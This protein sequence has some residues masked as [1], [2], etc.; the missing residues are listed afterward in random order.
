MERSND[1]YGS[2]RMWFGLSVLVIILCAILFFVGRYGSLMYAA[3]HVPPA[4][5]STPPPTAQ[6]FFA[7]ATAFAA[8]LSTTTTQREL[9]AL[10]IA[11]VVPP[12]G[13]FIAADLTNMKLYLFQD[14]TTTAEFPILTKGKPGTPWETPSGVYTVLTKEVDHYNAVEQVHMPYSMEFYGNYFI[15][16]WPT[17]D[18]GTP[19]A[20]TYSGG[21]IRLSTT[22]AEKVYTF[23]GRGTGVFV[24]DNG[25]TTSPSSIIMDNDL[26][27]SISASAY[28]VADI[29]TGDVYA[30]S[31]GQEQLSIASITKLMTALVANET[32]LFDHEVTV[33]REAL[34]DIDAATDTAP[35]T[36][37]IG[38]LLYP[39]LMESS[40]TIADTLA[41]Y[42]GTNAFVEWM[43]GQAK[44]LDMASTTFAD[45]SGSSPMNVSTPE[46][47]YRLAVYLSN[48]KSFV[49]NIT[50]TPQKTITAKDGSNY[51]FY[52]SN[53]FSDAGSFIGGTAGR[54]A[55]AGD[56]MVSA[57]VMPVG[58]RD[59]RIA[60]IVLGS[61]DYTADTQDLI[62]W[63]DQSA[64]TIAD[65]ACAACTIPRY[66]KIQL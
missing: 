53:E 63:F 48:K 44:A 52:S 59:R 42:Y 46:D 50:R 24:Y 38:D 41:Q 5:A 66:R 26:V 10:T 33:P 3:A 32:I 16:G 20:S 34:Q 4:P 17:Y 31:A 21:C 25:A 14:G 9:G 58:G 12:T 37:A 65:T 54:T 13:K 30:E 11:D 43:N 56:A 47:L 27:P 57:F 19:V 2:Y 61:S 64:T 23:A 6:S 51:T 18:D 8:T 45:A 36:F 7:T 39:L 49:W 60:I 1:R 35:E 62:A 29:D 40:S 15:H 22:D 28:L 55:Q